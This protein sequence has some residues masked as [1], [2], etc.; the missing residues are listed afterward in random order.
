MPLWGA[1]RGFI[2]TETLVSAVKHCDAEALFPLWEALLSAE[3]RGEVVEKCPALLNDLLAWVGGTSAHSAPRNRL[4]NHDALSAMGCLTSLLDSEEVMEMRQVADVPSILVMRP[5][6]YAH[7]RAAAQGLQLLRKLTDGDDAKSIKYAT[8]IA[9][10]WPRLLKRFAAPH[11]EWLPGPRSDLAAVL[12][13]VIEASEDTAVAAAKAGAASTIVERLVQL[14]ATDESPKA[15]HDETVDLL[16]C[17]RHI[18][19]VYLKVPREGPAL[20]AAES[21][22]LFGVVTTLLKDRSDARARGEAA[23]VLFALGLRKPTAHAASSVSISCMA[24]L[25]DALATNAKA[26][27]GGKKKKGAKNGKAGASETRDRARIATRHLAGCVLLSLL[28]DPPGSIASLAAPFADAQAAP[29]AANIARPSVSAVLFPAL[30]SHLGS[31]DALTR[32]H[33]SASLW[34]LGR[35]Q[36][37]LEAMLKAKSPDYLATPLPKEL[38]EPLPKLGPPPAPPKTPMA[39]RAPATVQHSPLQGSSAAEETVHW[40]TLERVYTPISTSTRAYIRSHYDS[41]VGK[42]PNVLKVMW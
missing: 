18:L 26:A 14:R 21:D 15:A 7:D 29:G 19:G 13:A 35:W 3:R 4:E 42:A 39:A 25:A 10:K 11:E 37:S 20:D 1:A 40:E 31:P 9:D 38:Y 22:V 12:R 36:K 8:S 23:G 17:V 2:P 34:Q 24:Y 41:N 27:S 33:C 28:I 5:L 32:D 6:F 16:I 30:V